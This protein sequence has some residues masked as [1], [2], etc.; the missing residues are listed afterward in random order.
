MLVGRLLNNPWI[1]S[2]SKAILLFLALCCSSLADA[3][4]IREYRGLLPGMAFDSFLDQANALG[5]S[6][7]IAATLGVKVECAECDLRQ[8]N[9]FCLNYDYQSSSTMLFGKPVK[10]I[11][12]VQRSDGRSKI[13]LHVFE[14]DG[15]HIGE[16]LAAHHGSVY[17]GSAQ[18]MVWHWPGGK[19]WWGGET[20]LHILR[21]APL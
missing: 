16:A 2:L 14:A 21:E 7:S 12:Y 15:Q 10:S 9:G 8:Q 6:E 11:A 18:L 13:T 17:Q 4:V 19:T 1:G 20:T 5:C 3:E